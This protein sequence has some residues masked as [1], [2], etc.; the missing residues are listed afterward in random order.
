MKIQK[1]NFQ[2]PE[3]LSLINFYLLNSGPFPRI[4]DLRSFS[5]KQVAI[6]EY[7]ETLSELDLSLALIGDQGN[8]VLFVFFDDTDS[9]F[10]EPRGRYRTKNL[11]GIVCETY[12]GD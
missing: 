10:A 9:D 7:I 11:L 6:N 8:C 1:I 12:K 2:D 4:N 5:A 3:F